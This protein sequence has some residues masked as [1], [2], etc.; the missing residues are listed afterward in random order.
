[1]RDV[2]SGERAEVD[3]NCIALLVRRGERRICVR[4]KN[5]Q[6]KFGPGNAWIMARPRRKSLGLTQPSATMYL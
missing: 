3:G 1:M 4:G 6:L 2:K 5:I